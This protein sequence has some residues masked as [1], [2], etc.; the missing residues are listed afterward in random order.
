MNHYPELYLITATAPKIEFFSRLDNALALGIKLIQLRL[1]QFDLEQYID[2]AQLA[3]MRCRQAN[4]QLLLNCAAELAIE[5]NADGVHLTSSYLNQLNARPLLRTQLVAA[6]CHNQSELL[7][8]RQIAVDFVVLSPV[9]PTTSHPA[10][11]HLGWKK[12]NELTAN[13]GIPIYALGGMKLEHLSIAR[14]HGASGIAVLSAI[15]NQLHHD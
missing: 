1:P 5:L 15:W 8:A 6:S 2:F 4:A 14:A 3:I 10:V 11:S 7:K 9:L 12:F 13:A